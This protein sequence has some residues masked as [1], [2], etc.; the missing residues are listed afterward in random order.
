MSRWGEDEARGAA[1]ETAAGGGMP[2]TLRNEETVQ[3][4]REEELARPARETA[5]EDGAPDR[6]GEA[7][8]RAAALTVPAE[9]FDRRLQGDPQFRETVGR[10][11]EEGKVVVREGGDVHL[12][13]LHP[14]DVKG[15]READALRDRPADHRVKAG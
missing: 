7:S 13:P 14:G 3:D 9:E 12:G 10:L 11:Q 5:A 6:P 1:A 4:R 2:E 8:D 15:L